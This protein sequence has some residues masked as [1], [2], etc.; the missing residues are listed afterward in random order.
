MDKER[1]P[2]HASWLVSLPAG[3]KRWRMTFRGRKWS[4]RS[5]SW[6]YTKEVHQLMARRGFY[7][8]QGD[9]EAWPSDDEQASRDSL[10]ARPGH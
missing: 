2:L 8:R 9:R 4:Y 7:G 5:T 6:D 1:L 10:N 3:T